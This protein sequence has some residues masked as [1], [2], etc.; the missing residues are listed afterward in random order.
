MW[1]S[2]ITWGPWICFCFLFFGYSSQPVGI[3]VPNQGLKLC[4]L[5]W[6][7]VVLTLGL[8]GKFPSSWIFL[9]SQTWLRLSHPEEIVKIQK[10][11]N[12]I[13]EG[14][15]ELLFT[16]LIKNFDESKLEL[17]MF[18]L[19]NVDVNDWRQYLFTRW[20]TPQT[21]LSSVVLEGC[22]ADGRWEAYPVTAVC[23]RNTL[24]TYEWICLTLWF[25]WSSGIHNRTMVESWKTAQSSHVVSDGKPPRC[26]QTD[27][28]FKA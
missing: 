9:M 7:H 24:S 21:T 6:K 27:L 20:A 18:S 10:Q 16:D 12:A 14:F 13:L 8:P 19:S 5:Y 23:H 26:R 17:L 22:S 28:F 4:P 3:L 1:D 11:M 2:P 15:T 25:W